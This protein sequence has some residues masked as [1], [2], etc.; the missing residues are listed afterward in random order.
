MTA[1][2]DLVYELNCLRRTQ[3]TRFSPWMLLFELSDVVGLIVNND[4]MESGLQWNW[5]TAADTER[6]DR[7]TSNLCRCY[8]WPR[9]RHSICAL[10]ASDYSNRGSCC[11]KFWITELPSARETKDKMV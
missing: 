5:M 1:S 7:F 2:N 4:P 3:L 10:L 11:A 6:G 9:H 8:A